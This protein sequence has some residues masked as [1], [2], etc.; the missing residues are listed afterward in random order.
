MRVCVFLL[1]CDLL[2][3]VGDGAR[4]AEIAQRPIDPFRFVYVAQAAAAGSPKFDL[5]EGLAALADPIHVNSIALLA[6]PQQPA[7]AQAIQGTLD[8]QAVD[9]KPRHTEQNDSHN[10]DDS[11]H[12]F[13]FLLVLFSYWTLQQG[14]VSS[15]C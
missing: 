11:Y 8:V 7:C 4:E 5:I 9:K 15:K 6:T 13:H 14:G 12:R 10:C 1:G 3:N 2:A